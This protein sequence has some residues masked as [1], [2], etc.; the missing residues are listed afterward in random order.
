MVLQETYVINDCSFIDWG[1]DTQY[2]NWSYQNNITQ[3]RDPSETTLELTNSGTNAVKRLDGFNGDYCFEFDMKLD[4]GSTYIQL[5]KDT[6]TKGT[7]SASVMNLGDNQY[8]H[9]KIKVTGST[10]QVTVDGVDKTPITLTDTWNRFYLNLD[11]NY[12]SVIKYKNFCYY[13]I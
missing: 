10:V 12:N 9:I 13:P 3:S 8:H 5:R 6:S 2:T 4:T 1:T 11:G 7:I